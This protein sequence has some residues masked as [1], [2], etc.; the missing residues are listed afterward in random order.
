MGA[1]EKVAGQMPMT[2]NETTQIIRR[3]ETQR[4]ADSAPLSLPPKAYTDPGFFAFE[5]ESLF[6]RQWLCLGRVD[7]IPTP[8]DFFTLDLLDEPLL[9]VRGDD[10]GV[11]VLS[12]VCRHR[13]TIVASG[14]GNARRFVCPYHSWSYHR[15]GTLDRAPNATPEQ[16]ALLDNCR[17]ECL[18]SE[19]WQGFIYVNFDDEASPLGP[20]LT[21]LDILLQRYHTDTMHQVFSTQETWAT[22]WKSLIENFMEGY[23][24]STVHPQTLAPMAPT[25]LCE[26]LDG[27]PDWTGYRAHYPEHF[28]AEVDNPDLTPMEQRC[29]TLFSVLPGQ[30]VS[31]RANMLVYLALQPL[32]A[33]EVCVRWG[34]SV[35]DRNLSTGQIDQFID[36][37]KAINREDHSILARVQVGLRSRNAVAGP[38]GR[39]DHEGTV[40]DFHNYLARHLLTEHN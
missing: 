40:I 15:D 32:N 11:R 4:Q 6:R 39:S 13:N 27:G 8:G 16:L 24:L 26:K 30:V 38:L 23:H 21:A 25:R 5:V 14:S 28:D 9:V 35:Y 36:G 34:L 19:I 22:N 10:D 29:S 20:R 31:Q 2:Q 17:L 12:N 18:R 33:N 7:E 37:W 1:W 3:W